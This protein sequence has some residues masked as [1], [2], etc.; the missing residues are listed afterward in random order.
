MERAREKRKQMIQKRRISSKPLM[1]DEF[2]NEMEVD[3]GRNCDI[4][5]NMVP[6]QLSNINGLSNF[7]QMINDSNHTSMSET[8]RTLIQEELEQNNIKVKSYPMQ[9]NFNH[10]KTSSSDIDM[11]NPCTRSQSMNQHY[12]EDFVLDEDELILLMQEV[13]EE[14]QREGKVRTILL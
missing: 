1:V 10:Q 5:S 13:E 6:L 3:L 7:N 4:R 9:R 12:L 2:E 14:L 11:S 8:A